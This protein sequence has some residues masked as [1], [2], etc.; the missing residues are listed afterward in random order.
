MKEPQG[1]GGEQQRGL[2]CPGLATSSSW[3][4]AT[5]QPS[6]TCLGHPPMSGSTEP[7]LSLACP[8]LGLSRSHPYIG[9]TMC[10]SCSLRRRCGRETPFFP[11]SPCPSSQGVMLPPGRGGLGAFSFACLCPGMGTSAEPSRPALLSKEPS[12]GKPVRIG[13]QFQIRF[14]NL[15]S[16]SLI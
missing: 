7:C 6:A 11:S 16:Y 12:Q 10:L 15:I 13:P 8:S 1:P 14:T 9:V 4:T 2:C 3:A 5:Q